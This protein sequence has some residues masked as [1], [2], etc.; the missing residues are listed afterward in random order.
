MGDRELLELLELTPTLC[1]EYKWVSELK[2][3]IEATNE[4]CRNGQA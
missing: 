4:E 1:V 3:I 2:P